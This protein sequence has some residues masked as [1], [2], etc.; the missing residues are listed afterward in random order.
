AAFLNDVYREK[1]VE[2]LAGS[3]LTG[4][5]LRD[6][7]L[8]LAIRRGPGGGEREVRV[9]AVVAGLG[10][11]PN[12]ELAEAAG[13]DVEDGVR[14]DAALRTSD[15]WSCAAGDAARFHDA[16][17]NEWRRVEHADNATTMGGL[18]GVAMAGRTV[19]YDHTPFFYSDFFDFGYEAVGD[20]DSRLEMVI[21]WNVPCREGVIYYLREGRVRGVLLWNIWGQVDAARRLIVAPGSHSVASLMGRLGKAGGA[22][23]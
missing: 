3:T 9:D 6:E 8:V 5:E 21:D 14:G 2:V 1:G 12:V 22:D 16:V 19:V 13:L 10:V 17:L 18:A 23:L 7:E 20:I 11:R 4:C 15:P